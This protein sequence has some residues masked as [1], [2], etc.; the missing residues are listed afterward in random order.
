[1]FIDEWAKNVSKSYVN[2]MRIFLRGVF[3]SAIDNGLINLNPV[4]KVKFPNK[5]EPPRQS[6]TD[7]EI[8][9]ICEFAPKYRQSEIAE[10]AKENGRKVAASILLLI[11]TGIRK[12]ELLGLK[13]DDIDAE[14]NML[15]LTRSVYIEDDRPKVEDYTMKTT[16]SVRDVPL[17]P[18]LQKMLFSLPR[19]GIYI[20]GTKN[21]TLQSPHNFSR[22]YHR[23]LDV[24]AQETDV[25]IRHLSPHCLRHTY[26][27]QALEKGGANLKILQTILGHSNI[28][29]TSRY[30]H[31]D[32]A[33][34]ESVSNSIIQSFFRDEKTKENTETHDT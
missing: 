7:E 12:G 26:A 4:Q 27:T 33:A 32:F 21:G 1:M 23:F 15:R 31:P 14:K 30:M 13:W 22:A 18:K 6:Y 16:S 17:A 11:F 2:K 29:T 25:S 3:Q 8:R 20:F 5:K 9:R 34:K 19:N 10:T 28:A 24:M